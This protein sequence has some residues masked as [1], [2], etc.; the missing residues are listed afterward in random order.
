VSSAITITRE[1]AVAMAK[2]PQMPEPLEA[3]RE[4]AERLRRAQ[5]ATDEARD[6]LTRQIYAAADAGLSR[7]AIARA[8]GVSRQWVS[9]LLE[10]R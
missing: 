10:R 6:E 7:S 4:A 8:A 2:P 5:D 9:N 3:V 1:T